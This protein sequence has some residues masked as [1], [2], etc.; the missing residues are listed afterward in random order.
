[1]CWTSL[2]Q[3]QRFFCPLCWPPPPVKRTLFWYL[4]HLA[5]WYHHLSLALLFTHQH[6]AHREV[7]LVLLLLPQI[8]S[9]FSSFNYPVQY[10]QHPSSNWSSCF[11]PF[12]SAHDGFIDRD[13][14]WKEAC[15]LRGPLPAG[16]YIPLDFPLLPPYPSF[17]KCLLRVRR[18]DKNQWFVGCFLFIFYIFFHSVSECGDKVKLFSW[19]LFAFKCFSM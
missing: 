15:G 6:P 4:P 2:P 10:M 3:E 11:W 9:S 16:V 19:P 18:E 12:F 14:K 8:F 13:R 7:L 5:E 17:P 1:M